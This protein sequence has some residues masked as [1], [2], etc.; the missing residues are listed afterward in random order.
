MARDR[1]LARSCAAVRRLMVTRS[2]QN[3]GGDGRLKIRQLRPRAVTRCDDVQ[4]PSSYRSADTISRYLVVRSE[5]GRVCGWVSSITSLSI[6]SC[7]ELSSR[8]I[9]RAR[10]V[11]N[12]K[13]GG[14]ACV[15]SVDAQVD[16]FGKCVTEMLHRD[17]AQNSGLYVRAR[18]V[19]G[20]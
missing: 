19:C 18:R 10:L 5:C 14:A 12:G 16:V 11:E 3:D 20:V 15:A 13:Q 9:S 8:A 2:M 4:L 1:H 6:I 7:D 17:G